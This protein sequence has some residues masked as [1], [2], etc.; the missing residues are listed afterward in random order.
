MSWRGIDPSHVDLQHLANDLSTTRAT[1]ESSYIFYRRYSLPSSPG[2]AP[3]DASPGGITWWNHEHQ[4]D[5]VFGHISPGASPGAS[6]RL[7]HG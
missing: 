4:F 1:S 2:D 7:C 3:G 6:S 5:R